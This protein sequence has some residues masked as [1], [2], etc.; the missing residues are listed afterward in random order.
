LVSRRRKSHVANS[1][2][3]FIELEGKD[4]PSAPKA[5]FRESSYRMTEEALI[6]EFAEDKRLRRLG[7]DP[8]GDPLRSILS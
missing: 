6:L 3:Y 8:D 7:I 1:L 2:M 4:Y 5:Q